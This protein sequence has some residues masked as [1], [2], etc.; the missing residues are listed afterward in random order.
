VTHLIARQE[1]GHAWERKSVVR[2]LRCCRWR[3]WFIAGSL[4]GPSNP[5]FQLILLLLPSRFSS[6]KNCETRRSVSFTCPDRVGDI[7]VHLWQR[8]KKKALSSPDEKRS[9]DKGQVELVTLVGVTFGRATLQPGWSWST[10]VK[11]IAG[12]ELPGSSPA[13]PS[14]WTSQSAYG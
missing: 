4:V 2:K 6:P 11:P 1:H 13:V 10:C 7:G 8:W 3:S 12:T 14:L 5:Q 9:F